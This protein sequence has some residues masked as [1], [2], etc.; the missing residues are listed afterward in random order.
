[1]SDTNIEPRA[2]FDWSKVQWIAGDEEP[3]VCCYCGQQ[4]LCKAGEL[5]GVEIFIGTD[6]PLTLYRWDLGDGDKQAAF[7][8]PCAVHWFALEAF[9]DAP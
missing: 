7:C 6:A 8:D 9:R 5:D 4:L 3:T 2:G 1:M